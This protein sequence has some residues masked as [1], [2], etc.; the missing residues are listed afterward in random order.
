MKQVTCE[1]LNMDGTPDSD[2]EFTLPNDVEIPEGYVSV[3][4]NF[5]LRKPI[6]KARIIKEG[7]KLLASV[8]LLDEV[9]GE[10]TPAVGGCYSFKRKI[11][12]RTHCGYLIQFIGF[13]DKP[14]V[15]SRIKSVRIP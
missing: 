14:N 11:N 13:C 6:G 2:G 5:D 12:G 8:E 4:R 15:D 1:L 9:S 3:R 7:N 10:F